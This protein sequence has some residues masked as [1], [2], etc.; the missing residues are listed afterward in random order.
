MPCVADA[1]RFFSDTGIKNH[2]VHGGTRRKDDFRINNSVK[3][4]DLCGKILHSSLFICYLLFAHFPTPR[5]LFFISQYLDLI[6]SHSLPL[7]RKGA[8]IE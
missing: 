4:R 1:R 2:R 6:P 8:S 3:L 7:L 5:S